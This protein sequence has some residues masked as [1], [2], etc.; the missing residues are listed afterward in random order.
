MAV[1]L[2]TTLINLNIHS[3]DK[4]SGFQRVEEGKTTGTDM[5][6]GAGV[7]RRRETS[8]N[9]DLC[10]EQEGLL[11]ILLGYANHK[12]NTIPTEGYYYNDYDVPFAAAKWVL[13]G[14]PKQGGIYLVL[15]E[16]NVTLQEGMKLK[17]VDGVFSEADTNDNYQM[18]CEQAITGAVNTRKYFYARW[19]SQ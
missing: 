11:G 16:T 18:T 1:V 12:D 19:V 4:E 14:I 6:I 17:C 5:F 2:G 8:P 10:A 15:S 3:L 7:T 9:I 13:I